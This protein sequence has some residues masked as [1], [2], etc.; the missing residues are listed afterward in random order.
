MNGLRT[1]AL[2]VTL[3]LMLVFVG[4]ALGGKN[5]MTIALIFAFGMN[6]ITYWFSDKIVL[7]QHPSTY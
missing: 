1:M 6:F 7:N 3:T 4:A 2:M 5:G